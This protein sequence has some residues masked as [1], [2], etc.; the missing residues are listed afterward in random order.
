M[1]VRTLIVLG[2]ASSSKCLPEDFLDEVIDIMAER[3]VGAVAV[4]EPGMAVMGIF[5]D[6]D[7]MRAIHTCGTSGNSLNG[8]RVRDWM[9]EYVVTCSDK[10][11]LEEASSLM[12]SHNIHHLVVSS[13]ETHL[14]VISLSDVLKRLHIQDELNLSTI[15]ETI[16]SRT[17][18]FA[19]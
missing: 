2:E 14:G 12:R 10:T 19:A 5:T 6:H 7:V 16:L 13:G 8:E 9:S 17:G 3:E 15:K 18:V 11:L 4:A 1:T